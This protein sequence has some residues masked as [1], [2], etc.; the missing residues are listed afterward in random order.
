MPTLGEMVDEA[1]DRGYG[2]TK[3]LR[4][5]FLNWQKSGLLGRAQ[6][7]AARR[8]GEG[9]W[10]EAQRRLWLSHLRQ[11]AAGV[12]VTTLANLPVALWLMGEEGIEL[13]QARRAFEYWVRSVALT[14]RHA[15]DRPSGAR[16]LR[17]R[18]LEVNV[19]R[20]ATAT[21]SR[22]AR[23]RLIDLLERLLDAAPDFSVDG[24]EFNEAVRDVIDPHR[25]QRDDRPGAILYQLSLQF[26]ALA[27]LEELVAETSGS[28]E[29]WHWAR[30][31]TQAGI[32]VGR[33]S[34]LGASDGFELPAY[35]NGACSYVLLLFGGGVE[36]RRSGTIHGPMTA[37][38]G[39]GHTAGPMH[40]T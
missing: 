28:N 10:H 24:G 34:E 30:E 15:G 19:D 35:L 40:V 29:W 17:R 39:S 13:A 38:P 14:E 18:G 1:A 26:L 32:D 21:T 2:E 12:R 6:R 5:T 31:H 27:N 7:K 33:R 11:R 23:R 3:P 9:I 16:S 20:I 8:G 4:A 22:A 25:T 37:P 36:A